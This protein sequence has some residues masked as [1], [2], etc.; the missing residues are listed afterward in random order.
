MTYDDRIE[1]CKN[2]LIVKTKPELVQENGQFRLIKPKV[3]YEKGDVTGPHIIN[4][5]L[6][7]FCELACP[8]DDYAKKK[9]CCHMMDID[10]EM[11]Y[12][13]KI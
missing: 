4:M 8:W 10:I 2:P 12:N 6:Y 13:G 9:L 1:Y 5:L 3:Q 7:Q 11:I